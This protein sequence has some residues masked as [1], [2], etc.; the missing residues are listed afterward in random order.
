M[1]TRE[2]LVIQEKLERIR[3]LHY[4][5]RPKHLHQ[6][7]IPP[8]PDTKPHSPSFLQKRTLTC[9]RWRTTEYMKLRREEIMA[10]GA[11]SGFA[12]KIS[13]KLHEIENISGRP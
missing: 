7:P 9:Q 11:D 4:N 1:A 12:A 3:N 8:W 2:V 13:E 10:T 5:H 6:T